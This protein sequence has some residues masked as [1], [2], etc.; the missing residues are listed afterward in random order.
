[1]EIQTLLNKLSKDIEEKT[2]LLRR[3]EADQNDTST[4]KMELDI[5]LE[6]Y[7]AIF[8]ALPMLM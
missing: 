6:N 3:T 4:L 8:S 7:S 5:A 2:S 1:M